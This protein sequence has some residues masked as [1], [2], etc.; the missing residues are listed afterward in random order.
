MEQ[1]SPGAKG[2]INTSQKGERDWHVSNCKWVRMV[3]VECMVRMVR[4]ASGRVSSLGWEKTSS[5]MCA[6]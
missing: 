4:E 3:G 2:G 5:T 1:G 6:R